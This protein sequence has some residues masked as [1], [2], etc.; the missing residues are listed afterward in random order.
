MHGYQPQRTNNVTD[1]MTIGNSTIAN[2]LTLTPQTKSVLRHL[3]KGKTITPLEALGVYG[4]YRLAARIRELRDA[5]HDVITH[6]RA[7][8]RGKRFGEYELRT[9]WSLQ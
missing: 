5:G 9:K 7:D 8:E 4:I 1:I 2:D 6:R 3:E